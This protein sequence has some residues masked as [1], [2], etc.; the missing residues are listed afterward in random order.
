MAELKFAKKERSEHDE[1]ADSV[2]AC[3]ETGNVAKARSI[4]TEYYELYPEQAAPLRT[5]V[6]KGYGVSL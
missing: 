3:L 4:Y 2:Y 1:I 6:L 5:S